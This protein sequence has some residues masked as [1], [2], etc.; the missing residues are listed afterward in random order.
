[1]TETRDDAKLADS[2]YSYTKDENYVEI[3]HNDFTLARY[4]VFRDS[5]VFVKPGEWAEAGQPIGI[6]GGEKYSGGPKV[7]FEVFTTW[8]SNSP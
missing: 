5:S 2:N 6:A 3:S 1:V 8:S 4:S 7:R